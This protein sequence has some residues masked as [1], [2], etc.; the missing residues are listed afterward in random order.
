MV[1]YMKKRKVVN[2][3]LTLI[4]LIALSFGSYFYYKLNKIENNRQEIKNQKELKNLLA[5]VGEHYLLPTDEEPT[6]ATVSDP[7]LLKE[8]SFFTQTEKGDK[9]FIFTKAGKAVLYRPSIDKIIE[10]V[11]V[12]N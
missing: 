12:G 11:S 2:I 5:R 9:V 1:I 8:Q 7:E 3:A 4:A 6:V 10:I